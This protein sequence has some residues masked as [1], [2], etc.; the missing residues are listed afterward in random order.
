[1]EVSGHFPFREASR[2]EKYLP[3][4][5]ESATGSVDPKVG[6]AVTKTTLELQALKQAPSAADSSSWHRVMFGLST[7]LRTSSMRGRGVRLPLKF[8]VRCKYNEGS[9]LFPHEF[10]VR[11][12]NDGTVVAFRLCR[13][14]TRHN[15]MHCGY[16]SSYNP[17]SAAFAGRRLR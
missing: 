3:A 6:L 13:L 17:I 5:R 4:S 9:P 8:E 14:Q 11:F 10:R 1:M 16:L 15:L 12:C 2:K 7:R